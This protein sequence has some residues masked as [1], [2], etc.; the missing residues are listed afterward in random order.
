MEEKKLDLNSIIGFVLIFFIMVFMFWQNKPSE[1]ELAEQEK[2]KQENVEAKRIEEQEATIVPM[3]SEDFSA[4]SAT[5]SLGL[6]ALQNKLGA[7]AYASTLPSATDTETLVETDKFEL[8]FSNK[9]GYLSEVKMK[10]F[11]DYNKKPIYMIKDG[12]ARF[13]ISFSTTDNRVLNTQD[14]YFQ[15]T[16][17]KKGDNTVVSMKLKVSENKYLEYVYE[18]KPDDYMFDFTIRSQGLNGVFNSSQPIELDW[19]LKGYRHAKSI[20]YENRYTEV[21]YEYEG[22]KDDY[23]GQQSQTDDTAQ[24]VTYV[25]YKQHFFTSIL[26]ADNPFKNAKLESRNLVEDEAI[27][28]VYTK[29]FKTTMPMELAGGELNKT[30]DWYFGPSDYDVLISYDRNLDEVMPL[31]WGIFGWINRYV[32][33][34]LFDFLS[35]FLAPGIAIIIMTILVRILMSPVTYKSYVSQ[36]KMRVL[37]PEIAEIN[38]KYKDNAMKKQQETMALYSKAGASPMA[39]CLPALMQLPVF[40]A[41]FMF[42]PSAFS[43][44]QKPFLWAEDLSS[45]DVI[46]KLPFRIPFYGEHVSLFPILASVAIFIYMR[47]TTGQQM[48]SQPTQ[49]G[50]PDM[51]KM[52]KYMIY[53]SPLMMLFFFNNYASGLSLYYFVSNLITI[54]IMLVIKN[55]IIDEDKIHAKIQ[56]NK[57]KPKKE[58]RFQKKMKEMMEQAE[59]QRQAQQRKK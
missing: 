41:L 24:D 27:D 57:K 6:V 26:L 12:N 14:L 38:E 5:D 53:I 33:I 23:L 39:G 31:G 28:T 17:T 45:Y 47:M 55:Y 58:N 49:E 43:L 11:V 7:F 13:N 59:Q 21:V 4:A 42:F 15:P 19:D 8:K 56:E 52:M 3:T 20:S 2:D 46:A 29:M 40:Y 44:R 30:M 22:G 16:V 48:A 37:K 50:M 25:A 54:G 1:E 36:A 32:F 9:G 34:P 18:L 51:T 35:A 10:E